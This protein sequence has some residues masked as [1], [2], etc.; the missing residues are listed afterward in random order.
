M[1]DVSPGTTILLL[2]VVLI[3]L[4]VAAAVVRRRASSPLPPAQVDGWIPPAVMATPEQVAATPAVRAMD[5]VDVA[6]A[7]VPE[8]WRQAI[9]EPDAAP[10]LV[11][12]PEDIDIGE[13]LEQARTIF[14]VVSTALDAGELSRALPYVSP[15]A[16]V[17]LSTAA[18]TQPE[19]PVHRARHQVTSNHVL[20]WT[21]AAQRD[22]AD[23][24][25]DVTVSLGTVDAATGTVVNEVD[26]TQQSVLWTL[27]R[28]VGATRQQQ[29][30]LLASRCPN[31]GAPLTLNAVGVCPYCNA[32]V[33]AGSF[34]WVVT[35]MQTR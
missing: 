16:Y 13:F 29:A 22:A 11:E 18:A 28:S 2:L 6:L 10:P 15:D 27:E 7:S 32:E 14:V 1:F 20:A 35:R 5:D 9:P 34:S 21:R 3:V 24:W 23:V 30:S 12:I 8:R 19:D 4:I 17:V 33:T 31:C 26:A 25:F